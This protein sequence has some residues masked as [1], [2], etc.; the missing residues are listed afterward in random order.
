MPPRRAATG[1]ASP[2][3]RK[4]EVRRRRSGLGW[5]DLAKA[6]FLILLVIL[7]LISEATRLQKFAERFPLRD[8]VVL[9]GVGERSA[10]IWHDGGWRAHGPGTVTVLAGSE[11]RSFPSGTDIDGIPDPAVSP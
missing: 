2:A 11:Q 8:H 7:I 4:S 6:E 5:R 1:N 3:N 9:I 10:A